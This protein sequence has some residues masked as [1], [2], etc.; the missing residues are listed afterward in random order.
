M[1]RK[2]GRVAD[3]YAAITSCQQNGIRLLDKVKEELT[4]KVKK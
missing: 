3:V 2:N 4:L 1:I